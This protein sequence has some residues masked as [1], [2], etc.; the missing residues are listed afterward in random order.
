MELFI[1]W[2]TWPTPRLATK[3][4]WKK[5]ATVDGSA[6]RYGL[7]VKELR[8][9]MELRGSEAVEQLRQL[10]GVQEVCNKLHTSPTEGTALS[11]DFAERDIDVLT[12]FRIIWFQRRHRTATADVRHKH[13]SAQ[14]GQIVLATRLGRTQ[15]CY[16][17]HSGIVCH[18]LTGPLFHR[19]PS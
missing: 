2:H 14:T 10:G 1:D 16:A 18:S 7:S 11:L 13:D 5:M 12:C 17:R 3:Q 4:I 19:S 6:A 15:R 9:L 8:Q